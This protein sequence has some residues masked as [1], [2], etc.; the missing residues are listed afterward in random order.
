MWTHSCAENIC[1]E[2]RTLLFQYLLHWLHNDPRKLISLCTHNQ[3]F[4]AQTAI[5]N[6]DLSM[7]IHT[8]KLDEI[9]LH[10]AIIWA[11]RA[12]CSY[13]YIHVHVRVGRGDMLD[14]RLLV[15]QVLH[16]PVRPA[17]DPFPS[18]VLLCWENRRARGMGLAVQA[19]HVHVHT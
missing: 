3:V 12:A 10:H 2:R 4:S 14:F 5:S 8:C 13:M 7:A 1:A 18:P 19:I 9:L 16:V 15:S 11:S 17:I 6:K